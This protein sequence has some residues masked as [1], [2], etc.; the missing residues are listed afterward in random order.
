MS[1]RTRLVRVTLDLIV[2]ISSIL[3]SDFNQV[4]ELFLPQVLRLTSKANKVYVT[5]AVSCLK[6]CIKNS[7]LIGFLPFLLDGIKS[8]CKNTRIKSMDCILTVLDHNDRAAL[9]GWSH[10]IEWAIAD[11]VVDAANEVR[12]TARI[13]FINYKQKFPDMV[14]R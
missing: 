7:G 6:L 4:L 8:P 11:G 1:E 3:K 12:D 9:A 10:L 2:Q 5:S 13:I 14:P